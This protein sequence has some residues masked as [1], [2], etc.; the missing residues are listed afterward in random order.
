MLAGLGLEVTIG[1]LLMALLGFPKFSWFGVLIMLPV[2]ALGIVLLM[3]VPRLRVM[4]P[5]LPKSTPDRDES[6]ST[7][8]HR[9]ESYDG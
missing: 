3:L 2:I 4:G 7:G 6:R 5:G 1:G 9:P 8:P